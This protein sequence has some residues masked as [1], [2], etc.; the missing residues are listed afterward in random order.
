MLHMYSTLYFYVLCPVQ[1]LLN[2]LEKS[3]NSL[4]AEEKIKV[5]EVSTINY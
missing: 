4:S 1:L 5:I 2:K 3:G